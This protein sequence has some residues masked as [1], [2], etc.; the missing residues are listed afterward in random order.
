MR[1]I[2]FR[3]KRRNGANQWIFGDLEHFGNHLLIYT[4]SGEHGFIRPDTLGQWTGLFDKNGET[5]FEGD[6][7]LTKYGRACIVEW[8]EPK[9]CFDLQPLDNPETL[10][11][12]APDLWDIWYAENLEVIGNVYDGY[13]LPQVTV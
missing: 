12:R 8:F 1:E 7:V 2:L 6:V 10:K 11:N 9:L 3:G 4:R 5:I 13:K